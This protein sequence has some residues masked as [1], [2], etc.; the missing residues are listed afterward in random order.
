MIIAQKILHHIKPD[1][2]CNKAVHSGGQLSYQK[3]G[4][5]EFLVQIRS[6]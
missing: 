4:P 3:Q 5:L 2:L 1:E 6:K